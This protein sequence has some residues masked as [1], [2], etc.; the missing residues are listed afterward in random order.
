MY[1]IF[2][3][4]FQIVLP[5]WL[6]IQK[7]LCI[8]ISSYSFSLIFLHSSTVTFNSNS[9]SIFTAPNL[10][11]KQTLGTPIRKKQK[12]IIINLR[13]SKSQRNGQIPGKAEI[14]VDM[15]VQR[16]RF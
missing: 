15:L 9:N 3:E 4:E 13:H 5:K 8:V 2:N 14:R 12:T 10:H 16:D 1:K 7:Q 6:D 11:Q